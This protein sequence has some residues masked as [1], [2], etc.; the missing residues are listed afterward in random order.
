MIRILHHDDAPAFADL[1]RQALLE[2]PFAFEA[3]PE[4]DLFASPE[5][6]RQQLRRSPEAVIIGAFQ[7]QLVGKPDPA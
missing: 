6:V 2:Q 3:S 7:E 1:R 5:T 4:D